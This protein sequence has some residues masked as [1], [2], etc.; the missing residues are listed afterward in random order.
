M[1]RSLNELHLPNKKAPIS[2]APSALAK[3]FAPATPNLC[4]GE[5]PK[6]RQ[7]MLGRPRDGFKKLRLGV[8]PPN[9]EIL[10]GIGGAPN[11]KSEYWGAFPKNR[12]SLGGPCPR[13]IRT[14]VG[15][16]H[17]PPQCPLRR[18]PAPSCGVY[19]IPNN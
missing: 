19:G 7:I 17:P 15:P 18:A 4:W 9:I 1:Q 13:Q 5:L 8:M 3:F 14:W 16:I 12:K 11:K 6:R 2:P 10:G